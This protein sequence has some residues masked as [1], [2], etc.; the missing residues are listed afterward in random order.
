[1]TTQFFNAP[2]GTKLA[3]Q[4]EGAG[5][6]IL[7]LSG[8][9]RNARDFDY[10]TPHL[11]GCRVI[12]PDYRGRGQ[13]DWA[14]YSTY[15]VPVEAGDVL[16]LMDHLGLERAAILGTSRGGL[17]AMMLAATAKDRLL[18]VCLNDI[19]PVVNMEGRKFIMTYLGKRPPQKTFEEAAQVR[20]KHL[21][22][23]PNVPMSRWMEEVKNHY[24][25][26]DKGLNITYDP[27]LRSI[28]AETNMVEPQPDLWPWFDA[29]EGLPLAL[30]RGANSDLLAADIAAEMRR[31]RPDMFYANVP[32][33]GHVPFLDEA[34]SLDVIHKFLEAIK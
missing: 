5:V 2:D 24:I 31:R 29:M 28:V 27:A 13:S 22:D 6:P 23:F 25:Q 10:V 7:C 1:M 17:I 3:Y 4:D 12:R 18:G 21:H 11:M 16:A 26:D 15:T 19:G 33:R 14:E 32:D 8:L 34:E 9:T 20:A 30:I